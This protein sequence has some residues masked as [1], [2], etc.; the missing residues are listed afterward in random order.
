MSLETASLLH[1]P[2]PHHRELLQPQPYIP[3]LEPKWDTTEENECGEVVVLQVST[4]STAGIPGPTAYS[5]AI[6]FGEGQLPH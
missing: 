1:L 3:S 2:I 5:S 6:C 4:R